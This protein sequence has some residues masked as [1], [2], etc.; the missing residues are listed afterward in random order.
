MSPNLAQTPAAA[1]TST[2][3]AET[4]EERVKEAQAKRV[5]GRTSS[6]QESVLHV[7]P[8]TLGKRKFVGVD[9][10]LDDDIPGTPPPRS[11]S[12][13]ILRPRTEDLDTPVFLQGTPLTLDSLNE[14]EDDE[15]PAIP[16]HKFEFQG[17]YGGEELGVVFKEYHNAC[18]Q[19]RVT[20]T[21]V[22]DVLCRSG[23][24]LLRGS[25]TNITEILWAE[26]SLSHR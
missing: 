22:Q 20:I 13:R 18:I 3:K 4:L 9:L 21:Q 2:S 12:T 17:Q 24:L 10:R 6:A 14:T 1:S 19:Q 26:S 25:F 15:L 8:I 23:I 7:P 11:M 16:T 5:R